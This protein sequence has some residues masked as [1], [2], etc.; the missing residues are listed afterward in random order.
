MN[1]FISRRP[2][3]ASATSVCVIPHKGEYFVPKHLRYVRTH[4]ICTSISSSTLTS[5]TLSVLLSVSLYLFL[6]LVLYLYCSHSAA[7]YRTLRQPC[8]IIYLH[9]YICIFDSTS[10]LYL[11]LSLSLLRLRLHP[12]FLK[13]SSPS[14]FRS[15]YY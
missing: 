4:S 2:L 13:S 10:I 1:C 8:H 3:S 11:L 9:L 15:P 6:Y 5:F 14:S 12:F 7:I